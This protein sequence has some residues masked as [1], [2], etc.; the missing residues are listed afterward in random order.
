LSALQLRKV[1]PKMVG[2]LRREL[3]KDY[4]SES[5]GH[6]ASL[7][8][9]SFV[10]QQAAFLYDSLN[11]E[12]QLVLEHTFS[13]YGKPVIPE[14]ND[15]AQTLGWSPQKVRGIKK[16]IAKKLDYYYRQSNV[17]R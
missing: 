3:R 14:V 8:G 1:N 7:P 4:L 11:P 6:E 17:E 10:E 15:M 13:G 2:T 12:Q 9:S 16:Q 5:E